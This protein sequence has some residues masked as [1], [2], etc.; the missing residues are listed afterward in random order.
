MSATTGG[1][2]GREHSAPAPAFSACGADIGGGSGGA[3]ERVAGVSH[4]C[5]RCPNLAAAAAVAAAVE[6][7][8]AP[9]TPLLARAQIFPSRT[10]ALKAYHYQTNYGCMLALVQCQNAYL[11]A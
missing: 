10:E 9:P 3:C 6:G 5:W 8:A 4:R 11:H 1:S 2:G 7:L